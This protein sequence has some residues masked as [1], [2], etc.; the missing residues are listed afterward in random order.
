[1]LEAW[2][3]ICNERDRLKIVY[4]VGCSRRSWK[5]IKE[6]ATGSKGHTQVKE[7][8][9]VYPILQMPKILKQDQK[10]LKTLRKQG[11]AQACY[12]RHLLHS[13]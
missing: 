13:V 1:M 4:P 5:W 8:T 12:V 11:S 10:F 3:D 9:K 7:D 2:Q 6:Q